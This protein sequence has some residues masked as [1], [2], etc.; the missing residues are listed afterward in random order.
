MS[1]KDTKVYCLQCANYDT[2]E[3]SEGNECYSILETK[4]NHL[5][6]KI[7]IYRTPSQDNKDN[8]CVGFAPSIPHRI[9]KFI[10]KLFGGK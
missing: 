7:P 2:S 1:K 8:N 9:C 10:I 4:T 6:G 5:S 3:H